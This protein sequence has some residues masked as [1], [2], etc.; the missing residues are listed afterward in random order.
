MNIKVRIIIGLLRQPFSFLLY[1]IYNL[2]RRDCFVFHEPIR[3]TVLRPI[4]AMG[5]KTSD[6]LNRC[7]S[8]ISTIG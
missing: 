5:L 8:Q 2:S 1:H 3:L 7:C 6:I 4:I